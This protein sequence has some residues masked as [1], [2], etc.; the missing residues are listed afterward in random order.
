VLHAARALGRPVK[1]TDDRSGSFLS[2]HHGRDHE[3]TGELALD[4]DGRFLALRITSFGNMGAYVGAMAPLMPTLNTA[5]NVIGVYRTPLL[6]VRAKCMFTNTVL[7]SAYRG[8]GRPEG[9]YFMERLIDAAAAE[10]GIDRVELRRRNQIKPKELPFKAASGMVYDSG[11]FP[12]LLKEALEAADWK[13]FARRRRDSRKRGKLRGFGIGS[14]LEVTA[15]GGKEFGR[16][17]FDPDGGVT[18]LTGTLDYGQ[19]HAAPLAQVLH[20]QLGIPFDRIRLVQGD[21]DLLPLGGG[22]GGSRSMMNS[23]AAALGAAQKVIEHGRQIAAHVLEASAADI[24][25]GQGRFVIAGTD[26]G[27]GLMELANEI[28][29]GLALPD[30]APHALDADYVVEDVPSAFPNGCHA[31]E[32]EIDLDTGETEVVSYLS[33]NDFGTVLN[34]LLLEGQVHGGIV[35]AL[36]QALLEHAVYDED[37][38]LVTG[39]FMDYAMPRASHVPDLVSL[40]HPVPAKTNPLGVKGCGEAGCAG[41]LV[42]ITNAVADALSE[43]GIRH[44]DM[45]MTP[46]RV[47]QA[48]QDAKAQA[49]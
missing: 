46:A 9:N 13:G 15:G 39:S 48:I 29:D 10:M 6:E 47:W 24:E 38:Q 30:D 23:G 17:R 20:Q 3:V 49:A 41:G 37:G 5:K 40:S 16:I 31:A 18:F 4:A 42:A 33:V 2:D 27:I 22:T 26:R 14:Y 35:Q 34:P 44:L 19:G 1:W 28:N 32:V 36:G 8:A 43:Y 11:D 7:V 21:S 12:A 45:P 25:F